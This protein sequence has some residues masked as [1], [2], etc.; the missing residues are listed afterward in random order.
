M[1]DTCCTNAVGDKFPCGGKGSCCGNACTGEGS[2]CCKVGNFTEWYPVSKDTECRSPAYTNGNVHQAIPGPVDESLLLALPSSSTSCGAAPGDLCCTNAVGDKFAC[3]GGGSCCGNACAGEG[4]K[5][6]KVGNFS[7]WYPVS[8][9]TECRSPTSSTGVR[10]RRPGDVLW[11]DGKCINPDGV[12]HECGGGPETC[13]GWFCKAPGDTCCTNA[14]GDKFPCGGKGP[15][16]GNACTGKGSKC[17]KVGN[18]TEWYP[19]SKDT[20]CRSPAHTT[21]NVQPHQAIPEHGPLHG[22]NH[23]MFQDD[24]NWIDLATVSTPD[25]SRVCRGDH[26]QCYPLK[27]NGYMGTPCGVLSQGDPQG[28]FFNS[29]T[30]TCS[31]CDTNGQGY[32]CPSSHIRDCPR[33]H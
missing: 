13:C 4:S 24:F 33:H 10:R 6:C 27:N 20:E 16:C 1:G 31:L 17:C 14:V 12:A 7:E 28:C 21:G 18:F 3:G 15:C 11:K 29:P 22:M 23:G 32:C 26:N 25:C 2:K 9:E 8:V 5:C 19:V 30:Q